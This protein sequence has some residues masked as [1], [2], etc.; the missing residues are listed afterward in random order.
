M[1]AT[2]KSIKWCHDH[3]LLFNPKQ[4]PHKQSQ[5]DTNR[6]TSS[7][8]V[9]I[10]PNNR[11]TEHRQ[12]EASLKHTSCLAEKESKKNMTADEEQDMSGFSLL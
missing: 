11:R 12:W 4:W 7:N 1:I 9:F 8:D 3:T 5:I 6:M 10:R 2:Y